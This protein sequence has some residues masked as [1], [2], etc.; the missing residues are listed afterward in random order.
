VVFDG[1]PHLFDSAAE[2]KLYE[3][4]TAQVEKPNAEERAYA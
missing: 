1:P 2:A 4:L 3:G